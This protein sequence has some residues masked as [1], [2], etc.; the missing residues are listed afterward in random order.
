MRIWLVLL[1]FA[2]SGPAL[3]QAIP[4]P[5][6]SPT[7][8]PADPAE[9]PHVEPVPSVVPAPPP[10]PSPES[11]TPSNPLQHAP[12]TEVSP[13]AAP[14]KAEPLPP[15]PAAAPPL[16]Q[17]ARVKPETAAYLQEIGIDPAAADVVEVS[18]DIVN[19]ISL[20]SLAAERNETGVR[21]FIYTRTFMHHFLADS[22]NL[23]I[24][25]DKYDIAFLT[26]DEVKLISEDLNK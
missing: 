20:D 17:K 23:R 4:P 21:R 24:E 1:A 3:A 10:P 22:N 5:S 14:P 18:Q 2:A 19:G 25:P 8:P 6:A 26:P 7:V 12:A 11:T 13:P 15:P 16:E 9:P